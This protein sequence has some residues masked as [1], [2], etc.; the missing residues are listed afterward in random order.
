MTR[1]NRDGNHSITASPSLLDT[2]TDLKQRIVA[3]AIESTTITVEHGPSL[4]ALE[5]NTASRSRHGSLEAVISPDRP[6]GLELRQANLGRKARLAE[7][8]WVEKHG[9]R[10]GGRITSWSIRRMNPETPPKAS[11]PAVDKPLPK[12]QM[13]QAALTEANRKDNKLENRFKEALRKSAGN[14]PTKIGSLSAEEHIQVMEER[15]KKNSYDTGF[16]ARFAAMLAKHEGKRVLGDGGNADREARNYD[17]DTSNLSEMGGENDMSKDEIMADVPPDKNNY[18]S[19]EA[20]FAEEMAKGIGKNDSAR[21]DQLDCEGSN[22]DA[23]MSGFEAA[24]KGDKKKRSR[25]DVIYNDD[26][27]NPVP[28]VARSYTRRRIAKR[29]IKERDRDAFNERFNEIL[30]KHDGKK[31]Q[32]DVGKKDQ[33]GDGKMDFKTGYEATMVDTGNNQGGKRKR[34]VKDEDAL[35]D[36]MQRIPASIGRKR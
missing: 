9:R 5:E 17:A 8:G 13:P 11:E 6:S 12:P 35:M 18:R 14:G 24:S 34:D 10:R 7:Q 31:N 32:M 15:A 20:R 30:A 4:Q 16:R 25:K 2:S 27:G 22:N 21:L 28:R 3:P 26:Y 23:D 33:T 36:S 19:L 29:E 1:A